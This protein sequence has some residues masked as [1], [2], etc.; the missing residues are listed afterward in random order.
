EP[1]GAPRDRAAPRHAP[2]RQGIPRQEAHSFALAVLEHVLG[3]AVRHAVAVLDRHDREDGA[4][5]LDLSDAD[6]RESDMPD[7][8]LGPQVLQCAK[9]VAHRDG[10]VDAV[11]LVQ[12]TPLEPEPPE[13]SLT[14]PAQML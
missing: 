5:V 2:G 6:L 12:I 14:G 13:A 4:R 3:L 8:A 11:Q 7:L 1:W 10:G 9:L